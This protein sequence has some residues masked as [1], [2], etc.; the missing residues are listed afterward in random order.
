MSPTPGPYRLL[1]EC[2]S[3]EEHT[4][5]RKISG[6]TPFSIKDEALKRGLS[7][8]FFAVVLRTL[9]GKA[10]GM[11]RVIGDGALFLHVRLIFKYI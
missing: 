4:Y 5:L 9:E 11:G 2:P 6:L 1:D 7:L 10:V 3:S 8:S